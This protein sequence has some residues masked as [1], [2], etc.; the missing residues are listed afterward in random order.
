[1]HGTPVKYRFSPSWTACFR[2]IFSIKNRLYAI[3]GGSQRQIDNHA[4]EK[5]PGN[6][7]LSVLLC[8]LAARDLP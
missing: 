6:Q 8:G 3:C 5:A 7:A 1:M 2:L 4:Q